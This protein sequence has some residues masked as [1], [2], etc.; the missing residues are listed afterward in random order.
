MEL[1]TIQMAH[2]RKA[3]E[4]GIPVID[5][6]IKNNPDSIFAPTWELVRGHKSG[7]LSNEDYT[8]G[9]LE[10]MRKSY[11]ERREEWLSFLSQDKVAILCFCKS[12]AFCHRLL[13]V[14]ILTKVAAKHGIVFVYKGEIQ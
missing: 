11:F 3:K 14:E 9:Y 2:W 4:L 1:Y 8:T 12:G 13:L 10:K 6:T 7:A 5:T